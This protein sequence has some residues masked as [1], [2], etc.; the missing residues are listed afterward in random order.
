MES[1]AWNISNEVGLEL[2]IILTDGNFAEEVAIDTNAVEL[3][4]DLQWAW[5]TFDLSRSDW[6][7]VV[8][9]QTPQEVG[10]SK[11]DTKGVIQILVPADLDFHGWLAEERARA[12]LHEWYV[13]HQIAGSL[14]SE[15]Q[16]AELRSSL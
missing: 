13:Q 7:V 4:P 12:M 5:L 2:A 9:L 16:L 14:P 8:N 3:P 1:L 15:H 10:K 11:A 6:T